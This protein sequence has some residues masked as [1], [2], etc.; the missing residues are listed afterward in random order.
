MFKVNINIIISKDL[1][2]QKQAFITEIIS[3]TSFV[4]YLTITPNKEEL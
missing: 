2:N 1:I 3:I 4:I